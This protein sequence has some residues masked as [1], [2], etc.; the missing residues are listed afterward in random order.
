MLGHVQ[1][2]VHIPD[3]P[4]SVQ[5]R[6]ITITTSYK[7]LHASAT[8]TWSNMLQA[9]VS[10]ML[11]HLTCNRLYLQHCTRA[12]LGRH[13]TPLS[14]CAR[15]MFRRRNW[16][17]QSGSVGLNLCINM[18]KGRLHVCYF[19]LEYA[20]SFWRRS[21][22]EISFFSLT[23]TMLFSKMN[24]RAP[25]TQVTNLCGLCF[26]QKTNFLSLFIFQ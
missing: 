22:N 20:A 21:S 3:D 26:A 13:W 4:Q 23:F 7:C 2:W 12:M 8:S 19:L 10:L 16:I 15:A 1:V 6:N 14:A 5:L 11:N 25:L 18:S 9:S 17:F 24:K